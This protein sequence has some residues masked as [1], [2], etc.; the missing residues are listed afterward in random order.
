M[1]FTATFSAGCPGEP[2]GPPCIPRKIVPDSEK[3][4][5][6]EP[7]EEHR[8]EREWSA[9]ASNF[10]TNVKCQF[11]LYPLGI[12]NYMSTIY[13]EISV[14]KESS[15][16]SGGKVLHYK[17]HKLQVHTCASRPHACDQAVTRLLNPCFSCRNCS[18][19]TQF[20]LGIMPAPFGWFLSGSMPPLNTL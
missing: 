11:A 10:T 16:Y 20:S 7:L 3:G 8:D 15:V 9:E 2:N 18:T 17:A 5:A 6:I 4:T 14:A 19:A 13:D 1:F 12:P